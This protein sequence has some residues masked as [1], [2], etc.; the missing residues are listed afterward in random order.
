M[1]VFLL[2]TSTFA[3]MV[4]AFNDTAENGGNI[5]N[6]AFSL[7][8]IF[9]GVL[10]TPETFPRFWI[11]LYRVSPFTY[12]A[13]VRP[14]LPSESLLLPEP[15]SDLDL[16]EPQGLL[17]TAVGGTQVVCAAQELI[18]FNP[19]GGQTCGD[20]MAPYIAVAGGSLVDGAATSNCQFCQLTDTNTFLETFS[21]SY[22][23]RWR[24]CVYPVL[25]ASGLSRP[26]SPPRPTDSAL[27]LQ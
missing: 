22:G 4:I 12:L 1:W 6:L 24:E 20:Y 23:N 10:A 21:Y 25:P 19:P 17:A 16:L 26:S 7:C 11:F 3:H 2:F 15:A 14:R 13:E 8:L 9:C 18:T 27:P 5:A